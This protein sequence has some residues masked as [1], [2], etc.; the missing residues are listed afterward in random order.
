M[1]CFIFT[2]SHFVNL[3]L[4]ITVCLIYYFNQFIN[5]EK[6]TTRLWVYQDVYLLNVKFTLQYKYINDNTNILL[7]CCVYFTMTTT[8]IIVIFYENI[9]SLQQH[10]LAPQHMDCQISCL[11]NVE[12]KILVQEHIKLAQSI[13][14]QLISNDAQQQNMT[15]NTRRNA[16]CAINYFT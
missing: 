9:I 6:S 10:T 3:I 2:I 14:F 5:Q 1:A 12:L 7:L 11:H 15:L 13:C 16:E 8:H 4:Q